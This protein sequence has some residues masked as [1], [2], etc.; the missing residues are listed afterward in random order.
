MGQSVV[1]YYDPAPPLSVNAPELIGARRSGNMGQ[2]R[3]ALRRGEAE[4]A[5]VNQQLLR[6]S[7]VRRVTVDI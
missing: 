6:S 1:H 4:R 5:G 7:E 2:E 3:G